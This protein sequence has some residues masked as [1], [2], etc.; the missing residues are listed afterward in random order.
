MGNVKAIPP[1]DIQRMSAGTGVRHS[2]FNH[3]P[4]QQTHFLQKRRH[5]NVK[6]L[7]LSKTNTLLAD[8]QN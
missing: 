1:G 6:K 3:A 7:R 8:N 5:N 4:Q 2:E